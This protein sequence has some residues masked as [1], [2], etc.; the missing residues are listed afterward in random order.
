M[1][2]S[3]VYAIT[4]L[5]TGKVYIGSTINFNYRWGRHRDDLRHNHHHNIH[6]QRSWNKYGE[7]I[8]EFS[9][10][11]YL[12]DINELA[13]VEQF[14]MDIY[15]EEGRDLYNIGK[16]VDCPW[17][18]RKFSDEHRQKL[19]MAK[20]GIKRG[21]MSKEHRCRIGDANRGN[22]LPP[23]SEEAKRNMFHK[24]MLGKKHTEE[25]KRKISTSKTG[26]KLG[27]VSEEARRNM[28]IAQR[29]RRAR[30]SY[31]LDCT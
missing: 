7:E 9:V 16:Y 25:S 5:E 27:P 30:E 18:G 3:G 24:G 2:V 21:P 1:I 17:R 28:I 6:L 19:S 23:M 13:K 12:D 4:N 31:V 29:A 20:M 14:W 8:F 22:K 10:L 26:K 15:R 11:E